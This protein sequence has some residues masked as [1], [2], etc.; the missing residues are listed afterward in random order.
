MEKWLIKLF[1]NKFKIEDR[2]IYVLMSRFDKEL[3]QAFTP[4]SV[5]PIT[6]YES[7]EILG[8]GVAA[9]FLPMYFYKSFPQLQNPKG[10]KAIARLKIN[11]AS[12]RS[13]SGIAKF[14]G[15]WPHI[16]KPKNL[17]I[18]QKKLLEDVFEAFLGA[19]CLILDNHFNIEGIGTAVCYNFLKSIF[20]GM[21]IEI[22]YKALFDPKTRL[23]ELTDKHKTELGAP[24]YMHSGN[25][26]EC[27][28]G[29]E[30]LATVYGSNQKDREQ[31]GSEKILEILEKRGY[32]LDRDLISIS[33]LVV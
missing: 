2:Y 28:V 14:L 18:N 21:T 13:F 31:E 29:G 9:Y 22:N 6:N 5:D 1:K 19:V 15:F 26:T 11:Y 7:L 16:K 25:K 3:T 32:I 30:L 8:D 17:K 33:E 23:K 10:V 24:E 12:R 4:P 27:Y 20:D